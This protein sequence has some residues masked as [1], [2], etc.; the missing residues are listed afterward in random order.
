AAMLVISTDN[1]EAKIS[2]ELVSATLYLPDVSTGYYR[3]ARFDWSGQIRELTY[4]GHNFFGLWYEKYDPLLHDAIMGP[5]EAFDPIG[6]EKAAPGGTFVK[7]GIGALE[8]PNDKPYLFANNYKL[9]NPGKWQMKKAADKIKFIHTL[10]DT[11]ISYVYTK[12]VELVPGK[13]EL[14]LHHTLKNTGK[15]PIETDVMNH[16]F[17]V[18]DSQVTGSD[19]EIDLPFEPIADTSEKRASSISDNKILFE[20]DPAGKNYYLGPV[21]GYSDNASDYDITLKNKKTGAGVNIKSDRPFSRL[22]FWA[23]VKTVCPEPFV[24]VKAAPGEEFTWT[25]TYTF[26]VNGN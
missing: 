3:G 4:K 26:F 25:T 17:F 2:N 21:T 8:K 13:P 11:T 5:V 10:H 19:F 18:I 9:V 1:P 24:Q 6:Y 16:N 12:T 23:S 14:V 22:A 7:I 15:T 20:N